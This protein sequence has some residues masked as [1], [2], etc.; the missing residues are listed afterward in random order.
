MSFSAQ[1]N[2]EVTTNNFVS[3]FKAATENIISR[4][5]TAIETTETIESELYAK[6]KKK[7]L[8]YVTLIAAPKDARF[9]F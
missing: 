9:N 6:K 3:D 8:V 1:R 5:T 4:S 2:H 7:T